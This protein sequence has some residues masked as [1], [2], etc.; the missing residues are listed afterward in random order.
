MIDPVELHAEIYGVRVLVFMESEPQSNKY[1]QLIFNNEQFR[2]VSK[3]IGD[4]YPYLGKEKETDIDLYKLNQ[5][6]E[7][8]DLP[9][10]RQ[11]K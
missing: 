8:Y 9:D 6:H 2:K 4:V 5:S 7:V 11:F 3:I 1:N 10:L